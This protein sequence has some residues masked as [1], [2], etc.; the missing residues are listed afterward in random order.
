MRTCEWLGLVVLVGVLLLVGTGCASN[1][2]LD[3]LMAMTETQAKRLAYTETVALELAKRG[4]T[5]M[6]D[7]LAN[8]E[9]GGAAGWSKADRVVRNPDKS[10][11]VD[12]DGQPLRETI[13]AVGKSRSG[14]DI[15]GVTKGTL[16]LAGLPRNGNGDVDT[17]AP[18]DGFRLEI[19]AA[20]GAT[21][22]NVEWLK[23]YMDGIANEKAAIIGGMAR[24][25]ESRGAAFAIKVNA[26][27]KGWVEFLTAAGPVIGQITRLNPVVATADLAAEGVSKVLE[28]IV[29]TSTGEQKVLVADTAS[30]ANATTCEG[31]A[32]K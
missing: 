29:N 6:A 32:L 31:S 20:A 8:M 10:V 1:K 19:E 22:P 23:T 18:F 15:A 26:V 25:A 4:G 13:E 14:R 27:S 11:F 5:V 28:A 16:T 2:K 17:A 9:P 30:A 24:L 7:T 3:Q 21:G 12:K